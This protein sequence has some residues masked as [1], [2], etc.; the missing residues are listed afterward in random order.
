MFFGVLACEYAGF[1]SFR[2]I[3]YCT[4]VVYFLQSDI[5]LD[6]GEIIV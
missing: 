1:V 2:N 3:L 6:V 5:I 4:A